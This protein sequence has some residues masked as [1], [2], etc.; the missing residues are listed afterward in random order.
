[1]DDGF[2][3][4]DFLWKGLHLV[5]YLLTFLSGSHWWF[6]FVFTSYTCTY[7]LGV[8]KSNLIDRYTKGQFRDETKTTIGVE[9]G[10][11]QIKVDGKD[12]KA[13]IW[14]RFFAGSLLTWQDTAGQERFRALTRGCVNNIDKC[15]LI[16][17]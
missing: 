15:R 6:G 12:I 7:V 14:V 4:H 1:M 3:G 5:Y 17:F 11:K 13:Q 2:E 10:H 16:F 8:G 9:F